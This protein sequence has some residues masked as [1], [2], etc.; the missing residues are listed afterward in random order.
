M[1]SKATKRNRAAAPQSDKRARVGST[2]G[3]GAGTDARRVGNTG[4]VLCCIKPQY[5]DCLDTAMEEWKKHKAN[6]PKKVGNKRY[7][8]GVYAFAYWLIR[9]SGLVTPAA[10]KVRG[11]L[12]PPP[13][14]S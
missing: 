1:K 12:Q 10:P 11:E 6:L 7:R 14:G 8:P 13:K 9:R 5:R 4:I 3:F 2:E